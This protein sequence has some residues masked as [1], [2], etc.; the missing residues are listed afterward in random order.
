MDM[1]CPEPGLERSPSHRAAGMHF[2]LASLSL[3]LAALRQSV[4]RDYP[5]VLAI[6]IVNR[7]AVD[8]LPPNLT[9][10]LHAIIEEAALNAAR[11]GRA[12]LARLNL[13]VNGGTV[14]LSVA[15]D[16]KGLPFIGLYDLRALQA[17]DAGPRWLVRR[18]AELGGSLTLELRVTGTRI[19]IMLPRDIRAPQAIEANQVA[20]A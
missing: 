20:A 9:D 10:T 15:D 7:D 18:V 11:H 4:E 5:M 6:D 14:L 8:G 16:G 19:D 1:Y 3:R 2:G 12:A 17:L 13:Q